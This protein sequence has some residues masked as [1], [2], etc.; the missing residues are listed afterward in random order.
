MKEMYEMERIKKQMKA[1]KSMSEIG[2]YEQETIH[3]LL[4]QNLITDEE[5]YFLMAHLSF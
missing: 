1:K 5:S 4:G 2:E 3:S